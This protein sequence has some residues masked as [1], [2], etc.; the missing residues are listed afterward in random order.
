MTADTITDDRIRLDQRK[1]SNA[2][3]V[4]VMTELAEALAT[5]PIGKGTLIEARTGEPFTAKEFYNLVKRAC[6]SAG[7]PHCSAH[8][9]RKSAARRGKEAGCTVEEGMA[10]TGHKTVKEYLRYAGDGSRGTLAD[11]ARHK[12]L[13]NHAKRLAEREA[14][15]IE[16]IA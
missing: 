8:G 7:L 13:A 9:L 10:I 16:R 6:V 14:Q 5:G 2:V 3:D 1:T 11:A 15:T 12:V 4:P